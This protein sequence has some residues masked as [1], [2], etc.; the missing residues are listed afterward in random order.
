MKQLK[1]LFLFSLLSLGT[2]AQEITALRGNLLNKDSKEPLAGVNIYL[3]NNGISQ[4]SNAKGEFSFQNLKDG[5]DVILITGNS[6]KTTKIP[7]TISNGEVILLKDI[8]V[9]YME[10][11]EN[12][13]LTG[14]LDDAIIDDEGPT[15]DIKASIIS[16][17][18][19]FLKT[20]SYQLSPFRFKERGYDNRYQNVYINGVL[21]NT[22]NRGT[23][24]YSSIGALNDVTR[25]GDKVNYFDPNTFTYG[26]IGGSE[27]I[28][29]KAGAMPRRGSVTGSFTNRNYYAR[30]M[31]T[32]ST[33]MMDDGYAFTVSLGGRYADEGMQVKGTSYRNISYALLF[34]KQWQNGKHSLSFTT[35]GSPVERGQAGH[36]TQEAYNLLDNNLYN[37]NW[38]Y[39][40]GKKRNSR[41]V[42]SYDP[43]AILSYVWQINRTSKLALGFGTHYSLDRRTALNWY[44]GADPRP[45]YYRYLPS[46][47]ES[48]GAT[49]AAE[50]YTNI[51]QSKDS[52]VTQ[53][54]WDRMYEINKYGQRPDNGDPNAAIYMLEGRQTKMLE[55]SFNATLNLDWQ[56]NQVLTL[57]IGAQSSNVRYYKEVV[58][59]LGSQYVIDIDKFG[60]RDFGTTSDKI[61]NDLRKPNRK[62]YED[63]VFGYDYWYNIYSTNFWLQNEYKSRVIDVYYGAKLAFT[64]YQRDGKMQNGRYPEASYGKGKSHNFLDFSLKGGA[65]YKI[66]G[67]QFI[68]AN[69]NVETQAPLPDEI[70]ISPKIWDGTIK[71][72]KSAKIISADIGYVWSLPSFRGR[73]SLFQT[74]F[75]DKVKKSSYYHDSERTYMHHILNGL[76][77]IHRGIELGMSYQ[78]N[79][80]WSFDFAGTMAQYFYTNNPM[81]TLNYENGSASA[82][83]EKVFM[84]DVNVG[85]VPQFAGTLKINYFNNF[86]FVNLAINGIARNYVDVA[87]IRHLASNYTGTNALNPMIP[88]E[89]DAFQTLINQ[90]RFGSA[91]TLDLSVSK[92]LYLPNKQ[93]LNIN[94]SFNNIL[95]RKNIKT[96]GYQQ[97][98]SSIEYPNRFPNKYF[99]MPGFNFFLNASYRFSLNK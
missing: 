74:Y 92:L 49:A 81:G 22:Q 94:L 29:M 41:M 99:Y 96:G 53:I 83:E 60:E 47:F 20:A 35:F 48:M 56:K 64:N 28:N 3:Q 10:G 90:E 34:E 17:N 79:N 91:Y 65:T 55:N 38:G 82:L 76:N 16:S 84:K 26:T 36:S 7:V 11:A 33:G 73:V 32:V 40:D 27:N 31:A 89:Y 21:F 46:Y 44:N 50:E 8:E 68:S 78:L 85:G 39:Q 30:G 23:F 24:N 57:G 54:D 75:L 4:Q 42:R 67:R 18:D 51:W 88:S 5:D 93:S 95:N 77:S 1:T 70:Y 12:I 66:S 86:W 25:N 63:D 14:I 52:F 69:V 58:D 87:P 72:V 45:D 37:P 71:D 97:G 80:N 19:V 9:L 15:Q 62:A 13:V 6:L 43:T 59:L 2:F 98:R 61:Q